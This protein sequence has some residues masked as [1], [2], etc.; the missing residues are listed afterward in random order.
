MPT[1]QIMS[2]EHCSRLPLFRYEKVVALL[3]SR[4]AAPLSKI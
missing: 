2:A 3:R 1:S 4:G